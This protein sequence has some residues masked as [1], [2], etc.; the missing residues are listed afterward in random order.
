MY[1]N[2][3]NLFSYFR[4][5]AAGGYYFVIRKRLAV[6]LYEFLIVFGIIAI[7]TAISIPMIK[8]YTPS[9]KLS[10]S[11]RATL[12][13]LRQAQEEAITTQKQHLVRFFPAPTNPAILQ[14]IK[15][16]DANETILETVTL[17]KDI[18]LVLDSSINNNQIIFSPDGG[19]SASG[20]ITL[21]L[22]SAFKIVN[23]SPAGVIKLQ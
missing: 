19:P 7:I 13:Q 18:M 10:S 23:V 15:K 8:N 20:N 22:E 17:D 2:T 1:K 5:P 3:K 4:L 21:N 12:A 14:L 6:S 9:L 16:E 11:A